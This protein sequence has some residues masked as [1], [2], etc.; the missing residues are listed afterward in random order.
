MRHPEVDDMPMGASFYGYQPQ[1][2][3]VAVGQPFAAVAPMGQPPGQ[4][5]PASSPASGWGGAF[6]M[7]IAA[8]FL[9]GA[10]LSTA[11]ASQQPEAKNARMLQQEA[12]HYQQRAATYEQHLVEVR[13]QVCPTFH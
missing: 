9:G 7:A 12:Q 1:Q 10:G 5:Q 3:Y 6:M 8:A 2:P 13:N 11:F 4:P